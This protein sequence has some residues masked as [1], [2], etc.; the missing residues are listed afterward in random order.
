MFRINAANELE[1]SVVRMTQ[2]IHRIATVWAERSNRSLAT[3][4]TRLT[5]DSRFFDKM[6]AG[7]TCTTK[8]FE[9]FL[10]FFRDAA[11]WPDN[12]IPQAAADL[13]D[14]FENI[15]SEVNAGVAKCHGGDAVASH[16][17]GDSD[18]RPA[19]STGL[20]GQ[21]SREGAAV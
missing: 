11:N 9:K 12:V 20:S 15:A 3:L 13:L 1:I 17:D 8:T 14:N 6:A 2:Q 4:G 16:G 18:D 21:M 5:N 10:T 19:P 7:G